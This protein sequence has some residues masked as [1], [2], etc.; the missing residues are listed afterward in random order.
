MT[1]FAGETATLPAQSW[2]P[3]PGKAGP[4]IIRGDPAELATVLADWT[5]RR[6]GCDAGG[7]NRLAGP[8]RAK[9]T[10]TA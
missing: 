9:P 7:G 3:Q 4:L 2:K 8:V 1:G 5:A 6:A 10:A